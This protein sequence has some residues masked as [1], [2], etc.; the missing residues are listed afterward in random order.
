[1][2]Y[3]KQT[4]IDNQSPLTADRMNHIEDGIES[5][6][7]SITDVTEQIDSLST[8]V[9]T[10][11]GGGQPIVVDTVADMTDYDKIY[12]Y[13]G[14]EQG[15]TAGDWYYYDGAWVDGGTYGSGSSEIISRIEDVEDSVD[16]LTEAVGDGSAINNGVITEAKLSS[17]LI[18]KIQTNSVRLSILYLFGDAEELATNIANNSKAKMNFSYAFYNVEEN[19]QKYGWCKLSLQGNATLA[20]PKH[21][22]NIQFY[23]DPNYRNKDKVDYMDLTDDKHPK[24]TLKANFN[25]YSHARNVVSARLWGEVV[26]SRSNMSEALSEAPNHGA[27]DGHPCLL[28]LNDEYY[29]LYM[30]NMSKS[31]WMLGIDED[32]PYDCAIS[33]N[34]AT[35]ATKWL[36]TGLG[37]WELEIPDSWQTVEESGVTISVQDG[38]TALQSFVINSTDADFYANLGN[39]LNVPSAIDYLI[40]MFC[41]CNADSMNKNQ[42]LVTWD[43]GKTWAFTAYDMDQTFGASFSVTPTPYNHDLFSTHPN[44][45]FERLMDNF[46]EE[47]LE[48]YHVLRDS[49]L[50]Y[51]Y[52]SRELELFFNEIPDGAREVDYDKWGAMF[53]NIS[54]LETMQTFTRNRLEWCDTYFVQ[55]DPDYVVCTGISLDK[56]AIQFSAVTTEQ[57]TATVT[58]SNASDPVIWTTSDSGVATV[59]INGLVTPVANGSAVITVSC[60]EQSATCNV[61]VV[62]AERGTVDYTLTVNVGSTATITNGYIYDT[63]TGELTASSGNAVSS[64]FQLQDCLYQVTGGTWTV[65]HVWD[66]NENYMGSFSEGSNFTFSAKKEY[67]YAAKASTSTIGNITF[68]PKNNSATKG[69]TKTVVID[70]MVNANTGAGY[71]YNNAVT[72][73]FGSLI[74]S[75][76]GTLSYSA[77]DWIYYDGKGLVS[78]NKAFNKLG[79]GVTSIDVQIKGSGSNTEV[80]I[81]ADVSVY[82]STAEM[83]AYLAQ[84]P[85]T[86][87]LNLE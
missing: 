38:F 48:R 15:Y 73:K 68:T 82:T 36:D 24:W 21:N 86:M 11:A 23:K 60:G 9:E 51:D 52:M 12:L 74:T 45:L 44:H 50:S 27:I 58:P 80:W 19:K 78:L 64:K 62:F 76:S 43:A 10:L 59:S 70:T 66:E 71:F 3:I 49:I 47:I 34:L 42:F 32:N 69:E 13:I 67:Y 35:N 79:T 39:Y 57:L 25:D 55:L 61:T 37:G 77:V 46:Y 75:S 17:A 20:Y 54:S 63:S 85:I 22:F 28:Y 26:H 41:V 8:R 33:A 18:E 7:G 87:I 56:S 30:Y 81:Y 72:S 40:F 83:N 29:G 1:M 14:N 4:W 31:D 5:A 6:D 16:D 53:R 65:I 2:A 84:H